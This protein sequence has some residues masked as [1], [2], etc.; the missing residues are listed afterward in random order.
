MAT[1]PQRYLRKARESLASAQAD[2]RAKRYNS[3]ANRAYYA[4][5]QAAV[6]GLIHF[7]IRKADSDWQHRFVSE[8][9]SGKLIVRR[10]LFER[11][12]SRALNNLFTFR[13]KGDYR[14][15]D[16]SSRDARDGTRLA[17]AF[18]KAVEEAIGKAA[19]RETS[20]TYGKEMKSTAARNPKV[21]LSTVTN[22]ILRD[23]PGVTIKTH[24]RGPR[25]FTLDVYG[26]PEDSFE[27]FGDIYELTS[28]ILVDHDVWIVVIPLHE[29]DN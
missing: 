20:A 16:V 23:F 24:K 8:E 7:R 29:Q 1:E 21:H 27:A 9:F 26:A 4:A 12:F 19:I 22:R 3:A 6:A 25:D 28:D 11:R 18:V 13:I 17:E 14:L 2:V 10:K 5:F 15:A